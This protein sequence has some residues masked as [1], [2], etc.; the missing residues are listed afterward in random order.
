MIRWNVAYYVNATITLLILVFSAVS[1]AASI[2]GSNSRA[3]SYRIPRLRGRKFV[4]NMV[5]DV[6]LIE[7]KGLQHSQET[8]ELGRHHT[9]SQNNENEYEIRYGTVLLLG[10]SIEE[11]D[12]SPA[13]DLGA[14]SSHGMDVEYDFGRQH[15]LLERKRLKGNNLKA[16]KTSKSGSERKQMDKQTASRRSKRTTMR[17]KSNL[18]VDV[19][20]LESFLLEK[21]KKREKRQER[22]Q[23]LTTK[24]LSEMKSRL[25]KDEE[26]ERFLKSSEDQSYA[27]TGIPTPSPI[28]NSHEPT[29]VD[30]IPTLCEII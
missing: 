10:A 4:E 24:S 3:S 18:D 9:N 12:L 23:T 13:Q 22:L 28:A 15:K 8:Q 1:T 29:A 14:E 6:H 11:A 25:V 16:R 26:L 19:E 30:F 21:K 7:S 5:A 17:K 20:Y 27:Y 2:D